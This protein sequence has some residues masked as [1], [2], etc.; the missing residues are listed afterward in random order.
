MKFERQWANQR[1]IRMVYSQFMLFI[2][3]EKAGWLTHC[4]RRAEHHHSE[5]VLC[6]RRV[7][8]PPELRFVPSPVTVLQIIW[9]KNWHGEFQQQGAWL[10]YSFDIFHLLDLQEPRR[11]PLVFIWSI[12][13]PHTL[14]CISSDVSIPFLLDY[15][16]QELYRVLL[17]FQLRWQ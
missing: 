17:H 1:D 15:I 6:M 14:T 3:S 7:Q 4:W 13:Q 8:N 10:P 2:Q 12:W 9:W 16:L 5:I 11:S